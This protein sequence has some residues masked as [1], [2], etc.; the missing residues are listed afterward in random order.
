MITPVE[1]YSSKRKSSCH[2]VVHSHRPTYSPLDLCPQYSCRKCWKTIKLP[3]SVTF[4]RL[5][6]L[7][8]HV[9]RLHAV[10]WSKCCSLAREFY[11][12]LL[13]CIWWHKGC[14]IL[15]MSLPFS[16]LTNQNHSLYQTLN[17]Y[18]SDLALTR[19]CEPTPK[20][21]HPWIKL[22][23]LPKIWCKY[24]KTCFMHFILVSS[25]LSIAKSAYYNTILNYTY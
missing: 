11:C 24:P 2:P 6:T 14:P 19:V 18:L 17:S 23:I 20:L 8:S 16:L 25:A 9:C 10:K 21:S 7:V 1:D 5:L 13:I 4:T 12:S 15:I 22:E 3:S